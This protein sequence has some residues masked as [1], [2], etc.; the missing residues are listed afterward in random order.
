MHA[1]ELGPSGW[2][3]E[4]AE[5]MKQ[6]AMTRV[7]RERRRSSVGSTAGINVVLPVQVHRIATSP[8]SLKDHFLTASEIDLMF[9]PR[10]HAL[11]QEQISSLAET[12]RKLEATYGAMQKKALSQ[13][14]SKQTRTFRLHT[15]LVKHGSGITQP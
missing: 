2:T 9:W 14:D 15:I 12:A 3:K 11:L 6:L 5:K 10:D 1:A 4:V 8:A 13:S 7:Q